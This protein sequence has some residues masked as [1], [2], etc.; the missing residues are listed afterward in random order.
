MSFDSDELTCF[1][2]AVILLNTKDTISVIWLSLLENER[3]EFLDLTYGFWLSI[4]FVFFLELEL[5]WFGISIFD[6]RS[7]KD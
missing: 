6:Y 2:K 1:S 3:H 7:W 5:I 4:L